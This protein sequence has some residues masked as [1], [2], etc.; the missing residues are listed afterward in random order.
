MRDEPLLIEQGYGVAEGR[1]Q[2]VA[3]DDPQDPMYSYG[4]AP[5]NYRPPEGGGE[6]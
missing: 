6:L 3:Y 5:Q 4:A 1:D 2:T